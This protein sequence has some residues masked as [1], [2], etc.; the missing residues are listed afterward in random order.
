MKSLA[1][2]TNNLVEQAV[3]RLGKTGATG[4]FFDR[5]SNPDWIEPLHQRG[6]FQRPPGAVRDDVEGMISFP[7]WPELRYLLRMAPKAPE[8][9]GRI[10]RSIPDT[11]N[12][13]MHALLVEIGAQLPPDTSGPLADRALSWLDSTFTRS[14]F[15]EYFAKFVAYLAKQGELKRAERLA[16]KL[17][18]SD[19]PARAMDAWY[20]ERNLKLCLPSLRSSLGLGALSLLRRLLVKQIDRDERDEREDYSYIWRR[21]LGKANHAGKEPRDVFI[22]AI[23]ETSVLLAR[24]DDIGFDA[25]CSALLT[26]KLPI[27]KRIAMYV[28]AQ[29]CDETHSFVIQMLFDPGIVDWPTYRAEYARLLQTFFP[30]LRAETREDLV[31]F[32]TS[33]Y[34]RSIPEESRGGLTD[35]RAEAIAASLELQ[36]LLAFGEEIPEPLVARRESLLATLGEPSTASAV[37]RGPT[38]ELSDQQLQRMSLPEIV[39]FLKKWKPLG[40]FGAPSPEGLGRAL[41]SAARARALEVSRAADTFIDLEPTYVRAVVTGLYEVVATRQPIEWEKVLVLLTWVCDQPVDAKTNERVFPDDADPG[42]SWTRQAIVRLLENGLLHK[43]AGLAIAY[44][45]PVWAILKTLLHDPDPQADGEARLPDSDYLTRAINSVR[46]LALLTLVRYAWWIHTELPVPDGSAVTFDRAPEV[47]D[48]L[49]RALG[50][51]SPAVRCVFGEYFPSLFY[52]DS[53]WTARHIDAIFPEANEAVHIWEA[54]WGTYLEYAQPY[55]AAFEILR[56]KYDFALQRLRTPDDRKKVGERGLGQHLASYFWRAVDGDRATQR[57]LEYFD[58]CTPENVGHTVWFLGRGLEEAKD[59]SPAT[60]NR[61]KALWTQVRVRSAAWADQKRRELVRH[62]GGWFTSEQLDSDWSLSE[63]EQCLATGFGLVDVQGILT[64]LG[65]LA[66]SNAQ[67]VVPCVELLVQQEEQLRSPF[68]WE[69]ELATVLKVLLVNPNDAV[70]QRIRLVV[71]K[72]VE[73]GSLFA[74]DLVKGGPSGAQGEAG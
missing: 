33:D 53:T 70:R 16:A 40:T 28:A 19:S 68:I 45:Q 55:D 51:P 58:N 69:Q 21:D 3:A 20:L 42:W 26:G 73:N 52:L 37:W 56:P 11:D 32:L 31:K 10:I 47:R 18:S 30:K 49:E 64:R 43:E 71:D 67:K 4:Y 35:Q 12:V 25:V 61:L 66:E 34:L 54:A 29:V 48:E 74:R 23:M 38:S 14:H 65:S 1:K 62:F 2:P 17:F 72:L 27:F 15:G 24:A 6:F 60:I 8:T 39:D 13:R 9:V 41:Q 57:L 59:T 7:D 36:R 50:D 5:L 44:R 63:L 46:G 22:D